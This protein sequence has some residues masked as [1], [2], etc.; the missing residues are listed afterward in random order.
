MAAADARG[1]AANAEERFRDAIAAI[2]SALAP[3]ERYTATASGE[4]TDFARMNRGKV[5]QAGSVAQH[6]LS[7]RLVR[8]S[9]HATHAL[10]MSGD[11][12]ADRAAIADA[13]GGLRAV[14]P[15]LEDDPHLLLP[16]RV[17]NS[18]LERAGELPPA[19]AVVDG[20]LAAAHGLDL[21][22]IYAA[23]PMWRGFANSEG[24]RNWHATTTFNLEWSLYD[25]TDKA[26][27]S[28][29]AGFAWERDDF[30]ARM[31]RARERL[32]LVARPAKALVP[33]RYRAYLAPSAL[34][35][36]AGL[37][38]W[39]GF[40]A[41][42]LETRQSPLARMLAGVRLDPRVS[43]D[44]DTAGGVAPAFQAE[45]F[46]RPDRVA[47]VRDGA[48][49]GALTSPR[50]AREFSLAANGANADEMPEALSMAGG[51]LGADDA[52]AALDTGLW[53]GNLW[54]TNYSDRPACRITGM[55]RFA[56]FWVERGRIVA[57]VDVLRFDDTLYRMLG[58][59]LEAL[60]R[61][62]ELML[63]A[64]CYASRAMSSVR[65]P[66]ALVR[67]LAFTL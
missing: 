59:N 2:E 46:A 65:V 55:T 10:A 8:G 32:A 21:V 62:T 61:E 15:D 29:Y 11:A 5:R 17:E 42:A 53:I 4:A 47:L 38:G 66:G 45:G 12:A 24:Q 50:T 34:D 49:V 43:I 25:R 18:R 36:I 23:G 7:V 64:E 40:S 6:T 13:V 37:L 9:R 27:K 35:E 67:E 1:V 26:V 16:E 56:T 60:T 44:E 3:G 41:R 57:P 51:D 48:L 52:L 22:G 33:G 14:L 39:G 31:A 19:E 54:Y 63:S 20:I 30:L 58:S 28:A